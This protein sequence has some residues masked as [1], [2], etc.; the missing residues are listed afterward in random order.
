M[1]YTI[2]AVDRA[3]TPWEVCQTDYADSAR[4]ILD[5]LRSLKNGRIYWPDYT[6]D[7]EIGD[8]EID[9]DEEGD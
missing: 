7:P 2:N 5:G 9:I 1:K 8:C 3:G 4:D 6:D